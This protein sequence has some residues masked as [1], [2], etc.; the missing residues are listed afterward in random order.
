M[1]PSIVAVIMGNNLAPRQL[2]FTCVT[3]SSDVLICVDF[4]TRPETSGN[5]K[6]L[7][8]YAS[9]ASVVLSRLNKFFGWFVCLIACLR[10]SGRRALTVLEFTWFL[11]VFIELLFQRFWGGFLFCLR[12]D[13]YS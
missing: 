6:F 9:L 2:S 13:F 8:G 4:Q 5:A 3:M 10:W 12:Q 11:N 7:E 1:G